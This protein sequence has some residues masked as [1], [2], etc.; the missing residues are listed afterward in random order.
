MLHELGHFVT[1]KLLGDEGDRVL[2]RL[3][4]AAVVDPPRRDR[5]RRE[6]DPGRRLRPH[7]RDDDGSRRSTP[8][9]SRAATAR[10]PSRAASPSRVAG[11]AMHF[12]IA[13][14]LLVGDVR[15]HRRCRRREL[16]L[17]GDRPHARSPTSP[18]RPRSPASEPGDVLVA[19]DGHHYASSTRLVTFI[20]DHAGRRDLAR[21]AARR[22]PRHPHV[23]PIDGRARRRLGQRQRV[24]PAK[25]GDE[26]DRR[27]RCRP[28][29]QP[30]IETTNALVAVRRAGVD[31]RPGRRGDRLGHSRRSSRRTGS[32][33]FAHDVATRRPTRSSRRPRRRLVVGQQPER[34]PLARRRGRHRRAGAPP[35]HLRAALHPRRDQHLRRDRQPL[36]D[37]ARSTA[38]TSPSPSTSG[39][40]RAAAALPRRRHAS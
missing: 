6:G 24:E 19:V 15:L 21:R 8:P 7:R 2:P 29:R 23:R 9:T 4:A 20:E 37:A 40:A 5:V 26:A 1:A 39:S 3:R 14:G 11:S 12:V 28:R 16:A 32:A 13:F 10:R 36:P 27:D 31:A 22:P 18:T 17:R 33:L 25:T 38:A 30:C 34:D 35:E